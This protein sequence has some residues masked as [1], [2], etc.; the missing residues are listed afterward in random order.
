MSVPAAPAAVIRDAVSEDL[1]LLLSLPGIEDLA[2]S[3]DCLAA[4]FRRQLSDTGRG[5][6]LVAESQDGAT[7]GFLQME[8]VAGSARVNG[9]LVSPRQRRKGVARALIEA[10]A[11]RSAGE[12]LAS[13]AVELAPSDEVG[14]CA[15]RK[16]GF[17]PSPARVR[18]ER[19]L[20]DPLPGSGAP[21][22]TGEVVV[23][24][25][26]DAILR[27][28]AQ[29]GEQPV[30]IVHSASQQRWRLIHLLMAVTALICLANT[31]IFSPDLVRGAVLP[32]VDLL[33]ALYFAA[34]FVG[35]RF[36]RR[37]DASQRE[38]QLFDSGAGESDS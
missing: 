4:Q 11:Q 32:L 31:D 33:F 28:A 12:G 19:S 8:V 25:D 9:L 1:E 37:A 2:Q 18:L 16:L 27:D 7:I 15:L 36:R 24:A 35:W 23:D 13:L 26:D 6:V 30:V 3:R 38:S 20:A 17:R 22:A 5:R 10:A 34:L 21:A 29:R 14:I